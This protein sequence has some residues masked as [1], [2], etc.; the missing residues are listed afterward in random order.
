MHGRPDPSNM[1]PTPSAAASAGT[2]QHWLQT[3]SCKFGADCRFE[4]DRTLCRSLPS[5]HPHPLGPDDA[6]K[7]KKFFC[8][9]C[10]EKS[11]DRWRC[12]AGCDY[13]VCV[14]CFNA[15]SESHD[16][17]VT[18]AEPEGEECGSETRDGGAKGKAAA[19]PA[20]RA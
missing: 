8:D 3:G 5:L 11:R 1:N 15:E 19:A 6:S 20:R 18:A 7:R 14:P 10:G 13:D 9:C 16:K 17:A 4:H 2:C 12:T